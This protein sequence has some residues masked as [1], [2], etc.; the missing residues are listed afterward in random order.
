MSMFISF[1]P[2]E[3][4]TAHNYRVLH[5]KRFGGADCYY[6][7]FIAPDREGA[8]RLSRLKDILPENN[9]GIRLIPQVLGNHAPS[10][11]RVVND[12]KAMGYDEV[13]LNAG[14]PSGTVVPKHKGAGMLGDLASLDA[15]LREVCESSPLPLSVKTRLGL[16]S[17]AEFPEILK[18]YEKYPICELIIH[19]RDR[20][21]MYKSLPDI[22]AYASAAK[23]TGLKL[24]YNGNI[25]TRGD[26]E[27]L[28]ERVPGTDRVML[29]RGAV[30]NPALPR[31]LRGG[32]PLARGELL[33][34][35][36]E[37]MDSALASGL[38][39]KHA[40][41]HFKELWFYMISLFPGS[42]KEFKAMNK[43]RSMSDYMSAAHM[44]LNSCEFDGSLGFRG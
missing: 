14:C 33:E 25:F 36:D 28:T 43:S 29:G 10:F 17:T 24:C 8:F 31:M 18:I 32:A 1:A 5:A 6:A 15:F 11:L 41:D 21:G 16:E 3:G 30:A 2:M 7:P 26:L 23:R 34:F 4:I 9:E 19:A 35:H 20:V 12:L 13:N 27:R 39:A 37:L 38:D 42:E 22:A 40:T 44:I